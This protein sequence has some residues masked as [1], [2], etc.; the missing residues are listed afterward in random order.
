MNSPYIYVSQN[1]LNLIDPTGMG[2]ESAGNDPPKKNWA[3]RA[4]DTIKSW[5]SSS[6]SKSSATTKSTVTV[7]ELEKIPNV[8]SS[9][10]NIDYSANIM[11]GG[12][13]ISGGL[14]A[15]D[16][17]VIGVVDDVAIPPVL[18]AT[19]VAAIVAKATYEIRKTME[20]DH[21]PQGFQ[22]ALTANVSG[23]YPVYTLGS[24]VPTG[25]KHLNVGDVWKYG[26]TTS[27]SRYDAGYLNSIGL[28]GV[29]LTPQFYGNQMQIKIVEKSKIYTYF[30]NNGQ[31]PPGNKIFR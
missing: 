8:Q 31:L 17:T 1:P 22:Y 30:I 29:T 10:K 12:L 3:G 14:L 19:G 13:A 16:V 6:S 5:F 25:T 28:G 11:M 4:V 18:L 9:S 15:D 27:S 20:R 2:E 21:G 23:D 24:S 26:E 7:G